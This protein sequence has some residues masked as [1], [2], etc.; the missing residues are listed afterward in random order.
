MTV[1]GNYFLNIGTEAAGTP[2]CVLIRAIQIEDELVDGPGRVGKKL[3]A[4]GLEYLVLGKDIP[5]TGRTRPSTFHPTVKERSDNS[6][7]RYRL[8]E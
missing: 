5:V 4:P 6:Q 8:K 3:D 7:G 1:R 2:S